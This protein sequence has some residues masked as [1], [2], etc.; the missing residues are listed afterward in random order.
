MLEMSNPSTQSR[1]PHGARGLKRPGQAPVFKLDSRS[2]SAWS[3]W[4]EKVKDKA[5]GAI[6]IP[7][8]SAWSAWIE[9]INDVTTDGLLTRS[10][11]AWSAWI[12]N[13]WCV[14]IVLVFSRAPH[15]ARGLK[16]VEPLRRKGKS[17]SRSAWS[18]WI[19]KSSSV[20]CA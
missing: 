15:G 3:A 2:R 18:A 16:I 17:K 9:N 10:R 8:R 14:I 5:S 4:I 12:E 19:E 20:P 13:F 6:S 11:S 7:S 1:A